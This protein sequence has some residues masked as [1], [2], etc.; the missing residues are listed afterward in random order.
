MQILECSG[1]LRSIKASSILIHALVRSALQRSEEFST[2]AVFHTEVQVVFRL[3]RVVQRN[4]EWMIRGSQDFLFGERTL[5][6]IALD[7]LFLG[8]DCAV[9]VLLSQDAIIVEYNHLS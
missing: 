4:D 3:K 2:A 8:E 9:L 1:D 5:D 7:H 6:L